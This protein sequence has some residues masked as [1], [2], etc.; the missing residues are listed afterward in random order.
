[1]SR[2]EAKQIEDGMRK[3]YIK[4]SSLGLSTDSLKNLIGNG[5]QNIFSCK[6]P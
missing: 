1:V 4:E 5:S 2:K 6:G 3:G